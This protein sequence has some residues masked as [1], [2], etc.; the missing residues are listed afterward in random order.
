MVCKHQY[1]DHNKTLCGKDDQQCPFKKPA[2]WKC[3]KVHQ[4]EKGRGK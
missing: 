4:D 1:H 2:E 3:L